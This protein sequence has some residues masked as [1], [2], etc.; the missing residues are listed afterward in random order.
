MVILYCAI[1]AHAHQLA[2]KNS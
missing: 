2:A 1:N